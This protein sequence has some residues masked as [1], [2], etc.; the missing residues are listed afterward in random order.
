MS[1]NC[2]DEIELHRPYIDDVTIKCPCCGKQMH[3]VPEVIDCWFDSGSMPF[4]QHHYPF[5]NK[6]LFEKQFP[7]DF[8]SFGLTHL[9]TI[10]ILHVSKYD[11]VLVWRF[12]EDQ[13]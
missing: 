1:D 11:N 12:V 2:P 8:I 13:C 5:E 4:A 10:L 3:R 7:A 9:L 6:E